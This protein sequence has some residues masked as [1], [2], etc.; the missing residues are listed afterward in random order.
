[1]RSRAT[2][3]PVA[4]LAGIDRLAVVGDRGIGAL[5]Y[6]PQ[7]SLGAD[8]REPLDLDRIA[9]DADLTLAGEN[10]E[11]LVELARLGGSAG[12][13]RPKAWIAVDGEGRIRSGA[14]SLRPGETGWLIKF[15]ARQADPE[16]IG[17]LEFAYA[18]MAIAAGLDVAEPWLIKTSRG[19][20][21]ASRRFDRNDAGRGHV[22]SAAGILA[23][24]PEQAI[25]ADYHDLL[26]LTWHVTRSEPEV[27]AAYRHAVFNVLAHNRDD[28]LRSARAETIRSGRSGRRAQPTR[29]ES[30]DF[31]PGACASIR[32]PTRTMTGSS[33]ASKRRSGRTRSS[34]TWA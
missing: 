30:R 2:T 8:S 25:A 23:V 27:A 12:G 21:F 22:L 9:A 7:F 13:S 15:R 29:S 24:V 26:R 31:A 1:L 34:S 17:R 16:D 4:Q 19:A 32:R 5:V 20:Y 3:V 18:R 6:A 14:A 28:H 10:T 11:L 33:T